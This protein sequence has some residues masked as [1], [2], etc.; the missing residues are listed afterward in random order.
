MKINIF[1]FIVSF[2]CFFSFLNAHINNEGELKQYV[3]TVLPTLEGWCS[4]EKAE[5]FIN[6]VLKVKPK[7]C[8]EIGVFGGASLFPVASALKFLDSGLVIAIDP[9]D[10]LECIK[11]FDPIEEAAHLNWWGKVNLDR[12]YNNYLNSLKQYGLENYCLTIRKSSAKAADDI[13]TIDILYIDGDH[14]EDG[15]T[16]DTL[17][18]LPKVCSGGYVWLNDSL[19]V[20][21]QPSIDLLLDSCDVVRLIDGGNCILFKKR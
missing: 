18:Y 5:N 2:F 11:N 21:A 4:E 1:K 10:K 14:S 16:S 6:L 15:F 17:L 7:V 12:V 20:Q 8:V 9:W 19:S 3:C 13:G